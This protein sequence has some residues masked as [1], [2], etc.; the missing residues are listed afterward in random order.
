MSLV[1]SRPFSTSM[2]NSGNIPNI[3]TN[4]RMEK[5]R[6][7]VLARTGGMIQEKIETDVLNYILGQGF[8]RSRL[9]RFEKKTEDT[10]SSLRNKHI[11]NK[12]T[13]CH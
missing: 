7:F 13:A 1:S 8:M 11:I 10:L 3:L 4:T 6:A 2:V 12:D 5:K 9:S